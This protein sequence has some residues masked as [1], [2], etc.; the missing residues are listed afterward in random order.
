MENKKPIL[1]LIQER[2]VIL[3][4]AMGSLLI[5]QGLP[6]GTPP[7]IWNVNNPDNTFI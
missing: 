2:V 5:D 7:E 6:P 4:G 3:D 1:D